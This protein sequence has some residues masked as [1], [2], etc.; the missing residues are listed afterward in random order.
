ML[1]IGFSNYVDESKITVITEGL[2]IKS[3]NGKTLSAPIRRAIATAKDE[4]RAIDATSGRG[5][6]SVL[7]MSDGYVVLSA[8]GPAGLLGRLKDQ[9]GGK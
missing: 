4:G 3:G 2:A 7:F 1:H 9:G 6:R 5:T 8:V